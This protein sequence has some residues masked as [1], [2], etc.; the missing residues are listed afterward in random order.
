M[1]D[2]TNEPEHY[3]TRLDGG[4]GFGRGGGGEEQD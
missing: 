4:D 1:G 3:R 2:S